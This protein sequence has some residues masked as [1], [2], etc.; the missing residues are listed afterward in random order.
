MKN[1]RAVRF[2]ALVSS[3]TLVLAAC[4]TA[5][6]TSGTTTSSSTTSSSSSSSSSSPA[7]SSDNGGAPSSAPASSSGG[8]PAASSSGQSGTDPVFIR[9]KVD[10]SPAVAIAVEENVHDYNNNTSTANNF[11]NSQMTALVQPSAFINDNNMK[12]YLD[13]DVMQSVTVTSSSPQTIVWKVNPQ[14]IW[15]DGQ[16][17][18]CKDFYLAYLQAE[19]KAQTKGA[20]AFD[21]ATTSGFDQMDPP[22]CS[23]DGKTITTKFT[24]PFADYRS[25]FSLMVPAHVIEADSGVA[26]VTKLK[27]TDTTGDVLKFAASYIKNFAGFN[28]K[29]DLSAGPYLLQSLTDDQVVMVRNPKWWGNPAGPQQLTLLT[30]ADGQSQVQSLQNQEVQVIQPQPDAALAEQLKSM[31]NVTFNAYAGVTFEHLDFQMKKPLFQGATGL[32]LRQAFF[33]CVDRTDIITKLIKGVNEKTVPLGSV[34]FLPNETPYKDAYSDYNTAN[35]AKA[36]SIMEAAGWKLGADGVYALPNGT[37]AEFKLGHKVIDTREKVAQLI[38]GY[39]AKAGIK[40][41]DDQDANFNSKRLPAG[42]YDMALFAWVGTPFKSGIPPLYVTKGGANYQNYSNPAVDKLMNASNSE[43]DPTKRADE[44]NQ[45]NDLIAKDFVTL[46]TYQ[47]SDMVAQSNAITPVLTY[48]GPSGG[49]LWNAYEWV[50]KQ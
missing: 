48:N 21:P 1:Q 24:T 41:D 20:P 45:A 29:F 46:P 35:V 47:F 30:K 32:A 5:S 9:P 10:S 26:D 33:N 11:S 42:D 16:P 37:K 36:K 39:C 22:T 8:S 43:L 34:T 27:A 12:L 44:L 31:D 38:N 23:A 6:S 40:V 4:S 19:S 7:A 13:G 25:L 15:S 2:A 28:A 18:G 17:V 14:A 50:F 3:A 49:S